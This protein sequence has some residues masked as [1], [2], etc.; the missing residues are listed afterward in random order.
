M[1]TGIDENKAADLRQRVALCMEKMDLHE[2]DYSRLDTPFQ[3]L[4]QLAGMVLETQLIEKGYPA[5]IVI[6]GIAEGVPNSV[7]VA[8]CY[9]LCHV[10]DLPLGKRWPYTQEQMRAAL[11]E[12]LHGAT[13]DDIQDAVERD[14]E[15]L[16]AK[17]LRAM[18]RQAD[19]ALR[20]Q[21]KS[22]K[23]KGKREKR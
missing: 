13:W 16:I 12:R 9:A 14:E 7:W 10:E 18:S 4:W 8:C 17:L 15:A 21:R 6:K 11:D 20:K 19:K 2:F 3:G 23:K 22:G 5:E 1:M